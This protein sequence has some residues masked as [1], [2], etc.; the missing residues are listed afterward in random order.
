MPNA[1]RCWLLSASA[2]AI[3]GRHDFD[4][5]LSARALRLMLPGA[6]LDGQFL[7]AHVSLGWRTAAAS[8]ESMGLAP[9]RLGRSPR[10]PASFEHPT[11]C[12]SMLAMRT[13]ARCHT[14]ARR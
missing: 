1:A 2:V 11:K 13:T 10:P 3:Q 8:V 4:M 7:D 14:A 5:T 9:R 12:A 6:M